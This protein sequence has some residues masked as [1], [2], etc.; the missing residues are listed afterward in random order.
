MFGSELAGVREAAA[1]CSASTADLRRARDLLTRLARD[2]DDAERIDQ[3]RLLEELK[4]AAAAA[5][6]RVVADLH[7]SQVARQRAHGLTERH[8]GRGVASQVGLAKRE[9]PAR[10]RRYVGWA[11][12][13]V[14]EL[15]ATFAE[16]RAGRVTEWR[17]QI[18][19]RE[20]AWLSAEQRCRVDQEVAPRL[21]QWSDR[22]VEAEVKKC[23]YR[24]DPHGYLRRLG[25]AEDER[26]VTLRPAPDC[27]SSLHAC[28]PVAQGVG[29]IAALRREADSLRSQGDDRTREQIMADTLVER[30]TGQSEADAVPA[31]VEL[32]MTDQT[33]FNAGGGSD[34]P[35]HLLGAGT[36]PAELARR[37]VLIADEKAQV[38]V[39]RLYADPEGRLVA[40]ESTSRCFDGALGEFLVIRDQVCRMPWCGAPIRHKDHVIP[41]DTDGPTSEANGEGLCAACNQGK[42]AP[43]WRTSPSDDGGAGGEASPGERLLVDLIWAA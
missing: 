22:Q 19:A 12:I 24:L 21:G 32:V 38:W 35:A 27:M 17:A 33:F 9:S 40:M 43:G 28:L 14:A 20:T 26:R 10:A 8:L 41:A 11:R 39:R 5:Q 42:E 37:L 3:I 29:V 31:R 4:S 2:V 7:D 6:A 36:V 13:L 30:V 18:V 16:L 23:A 25:R 1:G 34:E 15:P